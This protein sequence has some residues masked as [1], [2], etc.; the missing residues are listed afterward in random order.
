MNRAVVDLTHSLAS[1]APTLAP[2]ASSRLARLEGVGKTFGN[3]TVALAGVDLE[4]R[5]G[6]FLSLLGP[7]G[8]GKSTILRLLSDLTGP[9][10]GYINWAEKEHELSFVFQ[11]PTLMPWATVFD[12]VW[13][14]LRLKGISRNAARSSVEDVLA[15]VGLSGFAKSYPRELSG[16]MKMR[17]SVARALATRPAILLMDEPFAALDEIRRPRSTPTPRSEACIVSIAHHR[18]PIPET[19]IA[20]P[21]RYGL[22]SRALRPADR[23]RDTVMLSRRIFLTRTAAVIVLTG[24]FAA[25]RIRPGFAQ[26]AVDHAVDFVRTT[27]NQLV[28]VINGSLPAAEKRQTLAKIIDGAVDVNGVAQFCLGRFWRTASG[29]EQAEYTQLFHTVLVT[30]ISAKLGEYQG[31]KFTVGRAQQ[32]DDNQ[33]VSTTVER[34]N[35]APAE[36]EWVISQASGAPKIVDV[37]AEGTS[38][39]LT[40]RSDYAAYHDAQQQQRAGPHRSDAPADR[41]ERLAACSTASC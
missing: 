40:Q 24:A 31:V 10:I 39:R 4:V 6:E 14:P 22:R 18:Y 26:A 37:I 3:G 1:S 9:S 7:S 38:L 33:V 36:V 15:K 29:K 11:E 16:G 17:V 2:A 28:S 12:N 27:G 30:N 34:P 41:P 23:M 19:T 5:R 25:L 8:C 35:S 20:L 21:S 13:L 32:R